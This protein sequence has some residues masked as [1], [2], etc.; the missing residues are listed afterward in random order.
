MV[1]RMTV[2]TF[3]TMFTIPFVEVKVTKGLRRIS[4][5]RRSR[6][7]TTLAFPLAVTLW[8]AG[9]EN[10]GSRLTLGC[11][12]TWFSGLTILRCRCWSRRLWCRGSWLTKIGVVGGEL[13]SRVNL[14]QTSSSRQPQLWLSSLSLS[15]T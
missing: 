5:R 1:L 8:S 7:S 3:V 13:V 11:W 4:G 2:L 9:W 14:L 15:S 6:S 10:W 12:C